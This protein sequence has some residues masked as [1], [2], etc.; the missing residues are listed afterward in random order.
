VDKR[1]RRIAPGSA[2]PSPVWAR[3]PPLRRHHEGP[4]AS[5]AHGSGQRQTSEERQQHGRSAAR[6]CA[7]NRAKLTAAARPVG[8]GRRGARCIGGGVGAGSRAGVGGGRGI[9]GVTGTAW[10]AI[11]GWLGHLRVGIAGA[12]RRGRLARPRLGTAGPASEPLQHQLVRVLA[13]AA[14]GGGREIVAVLEAVVVEGAAL[15]HDVGRAAGV[16]QA[17]QVGLL[18]RHQRGARF[19]VGAA[20]E[21]RHRTAAPRIG[22]GG[23]RAARDS[24]RIGAA[25]GAVVRDHDGVGGQRTGVPGRGREI[26]EDDVEVGVPAIQERLNGCAAIGHTAERARE[27]GRAADAD[28]LRRGR[29]QPTVREPDEDRAGRVGRS[30]DRQQQDRD[31]ERSQPCRRGPRSRQTSDFH[32]CL[33]APLPSTV[34]ARHV[35]PL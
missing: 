2:E 32:A 16:L 14:A 8:R 5:L 15:V 11:G 27:R 18:L 31:R 3:I 6:A 4:I 23:Q 30:R 12:V 24:L 13:G 7:A 25:P 33:L 26:G 9:R 19:E 29:R 20:T 22:A 10:P 35:L 1:S 28:L 34:L 21:D 17:D